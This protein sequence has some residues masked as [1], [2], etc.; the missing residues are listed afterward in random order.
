MERAISSRACRCRCV[1]LGGRASRRRAPNQIQTSACNTPLQFY[2][3]I[4]AARPPAPVELIDIE[5]PLSG[6]RAAGRQAAAADRRGQVGAAGQSRSRSDEG[7]LG[8][9]IRRRDLNDI[10]VHLPRRRRRRRLR[11]L[12]CSRAG[13]IMVKFSENGAAQ[14]SWLHQTAARR[15]RRRRRRFPEIHL[16]VVTSASKWLASGRHN[17]R[18]GTVAA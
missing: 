13:H 3:W 18:R 2:L 9:L 11:R 6:P 16:V 10:E 15:R 14:V 8:R 1:E 5:Q 7:R 17:R 12:C 4:T